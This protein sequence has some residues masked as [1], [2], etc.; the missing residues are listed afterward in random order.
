MF[1]S[2]ALEHG[3]REVLGDV[4]AADFQL[5][6]GTHGVLRDGW[7]SING[8]Y[9]RGFQPKST[10]GEHS[11]FVDKHKILDSVL[12]KVSSCNCQVIADELMY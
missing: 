9:R 10:T 5:A 2:N 11:N 6:N 7:R 4:H 12:E 8:P 1:R 3:K